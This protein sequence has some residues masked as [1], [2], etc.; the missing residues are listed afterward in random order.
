MNP[1]DKLGIKKVPL[2]L[3]PPSALIEEAMCMSDGAKK[4]GPYNWREEDKPVTVTVYVAAAMRHLLAFM[5]G[6]DLDPDSGH[7]HLGHLRAGIGV[8]MDAMACG[9][10]IDDRPPKGPA[11]KLLEQHALKTPGT[12]IVHVPKDFD[13]GRRAGYIDPRDVASTSLDEDVPFGMPHMMKPIMICHYH[14]ERPDPFCTVCDRLAKEQAAGVVINANP[15]DVII[16]SDSRFDEAVRLV[17]V[18]LAANKKAYVG[19]PMRGY[20]EYNF[21]A[22]DAAR[23]SLHQRGWD[24]ISP[25][26][27]DRAHGL[28]P[29]DPATEAIVNAWTRDDWKRVIARDVESILSLDPERGDALALLPGWEKST[30]AVA[31]FFLARWCGLAVIDVEGNPYQPNNVH[32][33]DLCHTVYDFLL[34]GL[35]R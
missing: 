17:D 28:D 23:D 15:E 19:G 33:N 1:K 3:I 22:F 26:D 5:D 14:P 12:Q 8:V 30:G 29:K 32:Y 27:M 9:N 35:D 25:A 10:A 34:S 21:P 11:T 24:I 2:H 4:Y 16:P 18:V 6:E 31:E 13:K 20:P 7:S